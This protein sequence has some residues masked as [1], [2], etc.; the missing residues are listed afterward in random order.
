MDWHS[1]KV[2][3]WRLSNTMDAGFCIEALKEAKVKI[4][5]DGRSRWIDNRLIER[6]WRSLK[7]EY[8]FL[9]AFEAG[10]EARQGI[11]A[12]I[13]HYNEERPH[14]SRFDDLGQALCQS[15]TKHEKCRVI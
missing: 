12:W 5:M 10:L 13:V 7:Y 8:V 9:N 11:G 15:Q 2:L 6:L 1:R 4:S 14:S 3:S